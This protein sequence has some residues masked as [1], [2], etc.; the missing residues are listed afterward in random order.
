M[1]FKHRDIVVAWMD[2]ET[3]QIYREEKREWEDI[4]PLCGLVQHSFVDTLEYRIKP[5][6]K[7]FY[8]LNSEKD[9]VLQKYPVDVAYYKHCSCLKVTIDAETNELKSVEIIRKGEKN[10]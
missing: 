3:I 9:T 6:D 7:E 4:S 8:L 10:V 1:A 5:K 2:G